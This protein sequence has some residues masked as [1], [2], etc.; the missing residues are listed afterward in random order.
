MP[1]PRPPHQ[2][3]RTPV[4]DL[5][6]CEHPILL[7]GMGGVARSELAAAV[8]EAGGY[9]ILGMVRESPKLIS[10]EIDAVRARTTK[11]FAVNLIPA[12]TAPVLL[13]RLVGPRR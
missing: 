5:L 7:A 13:A 9:G 10:Q 8:A 6:G 11:P 4:C 3:L 2:N 1:N 12:A